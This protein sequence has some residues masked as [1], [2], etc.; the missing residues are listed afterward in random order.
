[1][2]DRGGLVPARPTSW[3][4]VSRPGPI[5][6]SAATPVAGRFCASPAPLSLT[7]GAT[8]HTR[9]GIVLDPFMG[10]GTVALVAEQLGL[11]WVGIEMN[12][13][14]VELAWERLGREGHRWPKRRDT[15]L[16]SCGRKSDPM[17]GSSA[18]TAPRRKP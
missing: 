16:V 7:A 13:D 18:A 14:Y 11:D 6:T 3:V 9:P 12:P 17:R 4:S 5:P 2:D 1:M 8:P 15:S 10:S